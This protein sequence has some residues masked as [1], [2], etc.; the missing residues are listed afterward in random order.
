MGI[1]KTH[2]TRLYSTTLKG[3][4]QGVRELSSFLKPN[5][6]K[7]RKFWR[8]PTNLCFAAKE[9]SQ[10]PESKGSLF[11]FSFI[12]N[13]NLSL[14]VSLYSLDFCFWIIMALKLRKK[15]RHTVIAKDTRR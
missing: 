6:T 7:Q 14:W 3:C 15:R 10:T 4:F 13:T 5:A 8:K 9:D 2:A 1:L 12:V 11:F